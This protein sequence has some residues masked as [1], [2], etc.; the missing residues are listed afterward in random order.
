MGCGG[1]IPGMTLLQVLLYTCS[2]MRGV[3]IKI[4]ILSSYAQPS[5]VAAIGNVYES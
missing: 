5:N 2:I 1:K 4:V 3:T